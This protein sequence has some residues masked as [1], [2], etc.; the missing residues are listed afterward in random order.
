MASTLPAIALR[1]LALGS[2][3]VIAAACASGSSGSTRDADRI[4]QEELDATLAANLYE[5]VERERPR[6]LRGRSER[7]FRLETEIIVAIDGRFFGN[8]ES[9][10]QFGP[11]EVR[12]LR[13][14]DG[15]TATAT[16]TGIG[17]RHVEGAILLEMRRH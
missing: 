14:L 8:V 4:S 16:L 10:R 3:A 13:Y 17:S 12:E 15:P 9:L 7:S 1:S 11:G 5:L 2:L 6:W